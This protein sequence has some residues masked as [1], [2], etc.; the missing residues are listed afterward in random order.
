LI[1]V[2]FVTTVTVSLRFRYTT[3]VLTYLPFRFRSLV[4]HVSTVRFPLPFCSLRSVYPFT[5]SLRSART[6][7]LPAVHLPLRS[8]PYRFVTA[9][10]CLHRWVCTTARLPFCLLRLLLPLPRL[11]FCSWILTSC[12]TAPLPVPF[13]FHY[14]YH[15]HLPFDLP[16]TFP[17]SH[18]TALP[19]T[20]HRYTFT[21]NLLF[22]RYRDFHRHRYHH[23]STHHLPVH[24][25][26]PLRFTFTATTHRYTARLRCSVRFRYRYVLPLQF[27]RYCHHC[28]AGACVFL[29]HVDY[30]RYVPAVTVGFVPAVWMPPAVTLR[31]VDYRSSALPV[32]VTRLDYLPHHTFA[33]TVDSTVDLHVYYLPLPACSYVC[34]LDTWSVLVVTVR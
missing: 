30:L 11:R 25:L 17:V 12:S 29:P 9:V 34:L 28:C 5:V 2:D 1:S 33:V 22:Y 13:A 18:T 21:W 32:S 6:L 24:V 3:Y 15:L 14:S 23:V 19:A 7:Q 4:H 16:P 27:C 8:L 31:F 10:S 26:P 20:L